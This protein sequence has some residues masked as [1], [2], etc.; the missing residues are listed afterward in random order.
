MDHGGASRG[1]TLV[2]VLIVTFLLG[3]VALASVPMLDSPQEPSLD[4]AAAEV[5]HALRFARAESIRTGL[6]HGAEIAAGQNRMRMFRLDLETSPPTRRYDVYEPVSKRVYVFDLDRHPF[7]SGVALSNPGNTFRGAC[8][9]LD[10][11]VF[12]AQGLPRCP[13]P[14]AVILEA[15]TL[16][17]AAGNSSRTVRVH[18]YT[19][20]V[21]VR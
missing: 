2:E 20:R 8:T 16:E 7:V 1:F 13:D 3:I 11:I 17:L 18:G 6:T 4:L 12:D 9:D 15:G 14:I 21:T 19:G 10:A 5:A